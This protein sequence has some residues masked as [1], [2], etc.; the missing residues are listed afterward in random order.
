ML[1]G[2]PWGAVQ[3]SSV[4]YTWLY[5][6]LKFYLLFLPSAPPTSSRRIG[7]SIGGTKIRSATVLGRPPSGAVQHSSSVSLNI[8]ISLLFS[9]I[10]F[11]LP[12]ARHAGMEYWCCEN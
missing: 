11:H 10:F 7:R 1:D 4:I 2:P 3:H 8:Y 5:L 12:S 6:F 9:F